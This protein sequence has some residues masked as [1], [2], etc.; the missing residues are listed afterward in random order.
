MS[1]AEIVK[2]RI[3]DVEWRPSEAPPKT[4]GQGN[5]HHSNGNGAARSSTTAITLQQQPASEALTT[6]F[7]W[8]SPV[9]IVEEVELPAAKDIRLVTLWAPGSAP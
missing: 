7:V 3:I 8:S 1:Q 6:T 9:S 4:N 2:S 5:G